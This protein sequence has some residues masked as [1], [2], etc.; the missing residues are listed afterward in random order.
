MNLRQYGEAALAVA[1]VLAI[2]NAPG[3]IAATAPDLEAADWL[4]REAHYVAQGF[5]ACIAF[6]AWARRAGHWLASGALWWAAWEELQ[7][8]ICGI[9][10]TGIDVPLG[11]GLCLV[12]AGALPYQ[13]AASASI[14]TLGVLLWNPRA[15]QSISSARLLL[16]QLW[17][18]CRRS[19]T[20]LWQAASR[21]L[22]R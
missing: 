18:A 20:G 1:L 7:V 6:V 9:G 13:L 8:A 22:A 3:W 2:T 19:A 4:A 16:A 14:A 17:P 10:S 11:S 5:V 12:R 21:W 15:Y